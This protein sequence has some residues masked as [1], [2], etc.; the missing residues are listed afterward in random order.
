M[1]ELLRQN[2][3]ELV[4]LLTSMLQNGLDKMPT[5][6]AQVLAY[7][8]FDAK[9]GMCFGLILV[10]GALTLFALALWNEYISDMDFEIYCC[11]GG[12]VL[13][14]IGITFTLINIET[15]WAIKNTPELYVFNEVMRYL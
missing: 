7:G 8:A 4:A 2:M 10:V 15:M 9:V 1:D 11:I 12:I 14:C 6:F 5:L 3:S 13:L